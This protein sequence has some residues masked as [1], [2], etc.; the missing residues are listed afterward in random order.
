MDETVVCTTSCVH[1][2]FQSVTDKRITFLQQSVRIKLQI[3][4]F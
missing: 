1:P 4:T 3:S 2:A